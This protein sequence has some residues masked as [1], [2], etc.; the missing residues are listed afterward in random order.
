MVCRRD[1]GGRGKGGGG[2]VVRM[3]VQSIGETGMELCHPLLCDRST[4]SY[5]ELLRSL[6]GCLHC[7][8]VIDLVLTQLALLIAVLALTDYQ[9]NSDSFAHRI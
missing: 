7:N 4:L 2:W 9:H 8:D 6:D 5:R 3:S 1:E